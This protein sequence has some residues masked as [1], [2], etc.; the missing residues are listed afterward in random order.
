MIKEIEVYGKKYILDTVKALETGAMKKKE[1]AYRCG[2]V[3]EYGDERYLLAQVGRKIVCLIEIDDGNRF[4]DGVRVNS[5]S[6]ITEEEFQ[7]IAGDEP[8]SFRKV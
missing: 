5:A 6:D 2:D 4:V 1:P 7:K 8:E 3:F